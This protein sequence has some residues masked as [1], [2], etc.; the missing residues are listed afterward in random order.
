MIAPYKRELKDQQNLKWKQA[1]SDHHDV[2]LASHREDLRSKFSS[3]AQA[4]M[5]QLT[6]REGCCLTLLEYQY[7][8]WVLILGEILTKYLIWKKSISQR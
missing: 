8:Q 4:Q 7:L 2:I 1:Q 5:N 3:W 6:A